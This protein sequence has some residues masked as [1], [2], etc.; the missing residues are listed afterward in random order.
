[1]RSGCEPRVR[2]ARHTDLELSVLP[3]K[4]F[5]HLS[6]ELGPIQTIY[7]GCPHACNYDIL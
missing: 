2:T 5:K 3:S 1:M 6:L 4:F 7:G